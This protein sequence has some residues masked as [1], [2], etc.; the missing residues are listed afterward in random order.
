MTWNEFALKHPHAEITRVL[1]CGI[2][3]FKEN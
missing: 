2:I 1:P 3:E